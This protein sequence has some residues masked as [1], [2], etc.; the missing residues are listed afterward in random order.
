[1]SEIL[2]VRT[3]PCPGPVIELR[4][5][6]DGGGARAALHVAD[7]LARSNVTRFATTRGATVQ[8]EPHPE[9]GFVVT[10]EVPAGVD[11]ASSPAEGDTDPT[12]SIPAT[13]PTAGPRVVQVSA[14]TM[15][16]GD[17][18]LGALL[19]RGFIKTLSKVEPLPD[20]VV[21]YNGA[22]RLCCSGS[23]VLDDI[24]S[25]QAAGVTVIACGTCLNF[26]GLAD[27]LQAG[28]VTDM[29]EI[30]STLTGAGHVVRP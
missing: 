10:V 9:G 8:A 16:S 20:S 29:L 18:E 24:R 13:A 11:A 22:V 6:L 15:G 14:P 19:L 27:Q 7:E 17:D 28:R 25:L 26:F 30:V 1:M 21:F 12:C 23:P 4:K 3:L 5:L 2:D